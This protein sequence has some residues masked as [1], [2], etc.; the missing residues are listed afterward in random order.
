LLGERSRQV[1]SRPPSLFPPPQRP[2]AILLAGLSVMTPYAHFFILPLGA[3]GG[4]FP[5]SRIP[6]VVPYDGLI[7]FE[8][9]VLFSLLV[10]RPLPFSVILSDRHFSCF[11]FR[12]ITS[13][14][15][16]FEIFHFPAHGGA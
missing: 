8:F 6:D 3:L 2:N 10:P 12:P 13:T 7:L 4:P 9:G 1:L 14:L 11:S 15:V 16:E 5:V